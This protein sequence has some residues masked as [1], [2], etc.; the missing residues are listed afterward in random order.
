MAIPYYVNM[1]PGFVPT[2]FAGENLLVGKDGLAL[3][4]DRPISAETPAHF[5]DDAIT[6]TSR[7]FIRN[8]GLP[9]ADIDAGSWTLAV[10]GLVANP[11]TM[12]IE[13]LRRK[14]EVVTMALTRFA[15]Q[16]T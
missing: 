8:N 4:N 7:H 14:F 3:L 12:T 9:P 2:A 10:D 11:T 16:R 1:P 6:P 5:L 13:D 15:H